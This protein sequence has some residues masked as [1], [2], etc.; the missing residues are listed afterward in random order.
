MPERNYVELPNIELEDNV[1]RLT[2]AAINFP[3]GT[4]IKAR[5]VKELGYVIFELDC[6]M[7]EQGGIPL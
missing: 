1:Y 2:E 4:E 3:S 6:R 5:A 7:I